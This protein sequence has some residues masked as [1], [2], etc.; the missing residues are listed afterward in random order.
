MADPSDTTTGPRSKSRA[1]RVLGCCCGLP[2]LLIIVFFVVLNLNNRP[3]E[4]VIP[5]HSVPDD[6]ARDYFRKAYVLTQGMQHQSP[7]DMSGPPAQTNTYANFAACAKDAVPALQMLR[8]GLKHPY[9]EPPNRSAKNMQF[10]DFAGFR[11]VARVNAGAADYEAISGHPG[12]SVQMRLDGMEM[13]VMMSRGGNLLTAL[14][15]IACESIGE[16]KV[17]PLLPQLSPQELAQV[18]DR[19]ER[20]EAKQTSCADVIQEEGNSDT[21]AYLETFRNPKFRS[22]NPLT[23]A[24]SV[25]TMGLDDSNAPF[26]ERVQQELTVVRFA[27]K[28]KTAML[29]ENQQW[30]R[31]MAEEARK[32]YVGRSRVPTPDNILAEMSG[33]VLDQFRVQSTAMETT[34]I[35]LRVETALYRYK[36]ANGHFPASL[37]DLC[38]VYLKS[39]PDDPF[40]GGANKPLRYQATENGNSFLLYSLGPDLHDEGGVP[41]KIIYSIPGDIVAGSLY[42]KRPILYAPGAPQ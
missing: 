10:R 13:G 6:N 37:T 21:A 32:P 9:M 14:V 17:E 20:I 1:P 18:A 36:A 41:G 35:L 39:V 31:A 16:S 23:S 8:E 34:V 29:Q 26:R 27:L 22:Q 3:P 33:P 4:L 40:G 19:L 12:R 25:V 15:G 24:A 42:K 30:Y 7:Y 11:E 5:T 28:S 38:P 2:V